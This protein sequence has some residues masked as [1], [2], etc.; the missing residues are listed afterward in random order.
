MKYKGI[1]PLYRFF[2]ILVI[3][4]LISG[5]N[6]NKITGRTI[7]DLNDIQESNPQQSTLDRVKKQGVIRVGYAGYPPYLIHDAQTGEFYGFSVD[8]LKALL[9]NWGRDIK[10]EWVETS[11]ERNLLDLQSGKFDIMVEPVYRLI[12]RASE[13]GFSRPYSYFGYATAIVTKDET[14]FKN[15]SQLNDPSIKIAVVS[16]S[17]SDKYIIKNLP[18]A[19]TLKVTGTTIEVA[20]QQVIFGKADIALADAPTVEIFAQ[21]HNGAVKA[22]FLDDP[23]AM[24]P[25]GFMFRIGDYK[26]A[27]FIDTSID[28]LEASGEIERIAMK[29]NVDYYEQPI[30]KKR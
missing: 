5:C 9:E 2:N 4:I 11:W 21:K 18:N 28:F 30:I 25:A 15:I 3:L 22:L 26:W 13:V 1:K 16:G 19:Q 27:Y 20:L 29:H 24:T 23:P 6:S 12:P 10:I 8:L 17:A 14:R 7:N